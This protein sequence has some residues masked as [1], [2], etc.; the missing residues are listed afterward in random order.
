MRRLLA[1]LALLAV[2][3]AACS[4]GGGSGS[5]E[6]ARSGG[7]ALLGATCSDDRVV[8]LDPVEPSPEEGGASAL[9][10]PTDE[11]F[12]APLVDPSEL[13][14]GGPPPDGIPAIDEPKFVRQCSVDWLGEEEPVLSLEVAGE[15]RAYPLRVMT[16]HE[17][18]NDTVGGAPVVGKG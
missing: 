18:V 9:L 3:A 12:P 17:I 16:W 15:A 2:V 14:A 13:V 6:S 11:D 5:R 1:L 8:Q 10:N 7:D 4:S